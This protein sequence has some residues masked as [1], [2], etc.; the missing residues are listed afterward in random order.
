MVDTAFIE[1]MKCNIPP[2][3]EFRDNI[4]IIEVK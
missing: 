4:E 3:A 1:K 2:L